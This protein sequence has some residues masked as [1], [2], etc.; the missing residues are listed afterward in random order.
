VTA[1]NSLGSHAPARRDRGTILT[2]VLL[3]FV[4][5]MD[6]QQL[7]F[8]TAEGSGRFATGGR[9]GTVYEVTNLNN[10]GPGSIVDAVSQPN[11]T[12]V[13][14]ISGTIELGSVILTPKSNIT[15]AGQT[16][17]GDGICLK[18]RLKISA[19]N[20]LVRYIRVRVDAGAA[21]SS[22]DAVDISNCSNVIV[23]HVSASYARDEG[24]SS[25]ETSDFVTVQWCIISEGLT[26]ESHSFGSL[27]RGDYGDRKTYHHNLYAH[28]WGRLPRPGNYTSVPTD[29][30]GLYLDFR[31]NVIYN[32]Q[33]STPGYNDDVSSVSRYNFIG[34]AYVAGLQ[35][36]GNTIFRERSM[37]SVGYFENNAMNGIVPDDPWS[38]VTFRS[39]ITAD[40]IAAYKARSSLI[41]MEPV[42]TTSPGQATIDVLASAGAS[43]PKRDTIDRRIVNDVLNKTGGS[44][45]STG[46]QPEGAWPPLGSLSAPADDDHDGM[47]NDWELSHGLDPND[48]ADRNTIGADGYTM[49]E[50]YLNSLTGEM[51]TGITDPESHVPSQF[52]LY[53][54]YPNPFNPS[55][56]IRYELALASQT[57][58]R[59]YDVYGRELAVLVDGVRPAG[60][61]VERFEGVKLTSGIYFAVLRAGSF[62]QSIKLVLLK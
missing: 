47:P 30:A 32:W 53:Q 42:K 45:A 46:E 61:H 22:G 36:G 54:N 15:I 25:T 23:D 4:N 48:P 39:G 55:T 57:M 19:S 44:I 38:L 24:I 2:I 56:S 59:I 37:V 51:T 8:P 11:R 6:G 34:N 52:V 60:A 27:I 21:N 40:Q 58:L 33:G 49:L 1:R 41:P 20:I 7:A 9:G 13:F 17:P 14:R 62:S 16:A 18:G 29:T 3:L 50:V 35:S 26:F 10:S 31:N 12:V 28:N 5:V 43:I